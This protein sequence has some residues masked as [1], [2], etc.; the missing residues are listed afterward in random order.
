MARSP[1]E[2]QRASKTGISNRPLDE[3][4]GRQERL[5]GRG[6]KRSSRG[7]ERPQEPEPSKRRGR[8]EGPELDVSASVDASDVVKPSEKYRVAAEKA[9]TAPLPRSETS[10][11]RAATTKR[12]RRLALRQRS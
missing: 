1:R 4:I 9:G 12:N 3:E 11:T 2:R 10:P 5:P 7:T 6:R 8:G